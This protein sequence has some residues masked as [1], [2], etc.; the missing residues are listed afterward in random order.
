MFIRY[1]ETTHIWEY[2]S[3]VAKAGGG[4]WI[5]LPNIAFL[6]QNNPF[7]K[8][9]YIKT[10]SVSGNYAGVVFTDSG[11]PVNLGKFRVVNTGRILYIQAVNDSEDAASGALTLDRLGNIAISGS[12]TER[13]RI[14]PAGETQQYVP[15]LTGSGVTFTSSGSNAVNWSIIGK[16]LFITYY[17]PSVNI[18][19]NAFGEILFNL[20]FTQTPSILQSTRLSYYN[21]TSWISILGY[22]GGGSDGLYRLQGTFIPSAA[23][24]LGSAIIF[25]Q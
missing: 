25:V 16:T 7:V 13:N 9:Q 21:G 14:Y 8:T 18:T 3:S 23:A 10:A 4:P 12:I 19:S 15:T 20:P 11:Q 5:M 17:F 1:N 6:D 24:F 2:D 22:T